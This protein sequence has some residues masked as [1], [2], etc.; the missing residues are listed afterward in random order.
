MTAPQ[1]YEALCERL[2]NY[3]EIWAGFVQGHL[4]NE[5]ADAITELLAERDALR[6]ENE[7]LHGQLDASQK[8]WQFYE[9][10]VD[11]ANKAES[12]LAA[13]RERAE[14]AERDAARYQYLRDGNENDTKMIGAWTGTNVR[15]GRPLR[16]HHT[17]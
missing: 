13:L 9:Y 16:T 4:Y 3:G 15:M 11:R 5:A 6:K 12:E 14:R 17:R 10:E 2:R 1:D 8:N 7:R